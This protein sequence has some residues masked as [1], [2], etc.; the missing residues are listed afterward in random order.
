MFLDYPGHVVNCN[1]ELESGAL[2]GHEI[3]RMF[4]RPFMGGLDRKGIIVTGSEA[5]I[6]NAVLGILNKAPEKFIL[7]AD[8]TLPGDINWDNIR[9]AIVTAHEFRR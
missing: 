1:P 8:C 3:S 4:K 7:A 2:T 6:T 5:E 9:T